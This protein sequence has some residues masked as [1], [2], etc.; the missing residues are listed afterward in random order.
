MLVKRL[1]TYWDKQKRLAIQNL[2]EEEGL[3]SDGL[4]KV[5]GNYLFTEKP[6]M[7]D[8]VIGIMATRPSLKQRGSVAERVIGK[9]K[10]FVETFIDGV[11]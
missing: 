5:I 1:N 10:D 9:I 3:N 6:P 8:D 2:S 7:R 4:E 11:D